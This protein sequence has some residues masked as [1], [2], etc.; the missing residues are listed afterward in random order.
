V[1]GYDSSLRHAGRW[2]GSAGA[3]VEDA[4]LLLSLLLGDAAGM[5]LMPAKL[6]WQ[7]VV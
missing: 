3:A 6:V 5:R 4:S 2:L 1:S 7:A